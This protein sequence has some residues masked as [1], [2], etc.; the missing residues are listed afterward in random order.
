MSIKDKPSALITGATGFVGS[1]LAEHL[2]SQGWQ[3]TLLVR[4]TAKEPRTALQQLPRLVFNGE[5]ES[6]VEYMREQKPGVIF[7]LA[8][9][10]RAVHVTAEVVGA[11]VEIA[12]TDSG[13]GIDPAFLP[14]VFER[15]RQ[16]DVR[17]TREQ[18]G[19]GLGLSIARSIVEMHGGTIH[20]KAADRAKGRRSASGCRRPRQAISLK[21]VC[22]SKLRATFD[23]RYMMESWRQPNA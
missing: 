16:A 13:R 8:S 7:H 23:S 15:F 19:L 3:V 10:T 5:T 11:D 6:L 17:F 18:G 12:V 21:P 1:H 22:H 20:G 4:P 2:A 14:H 9:L